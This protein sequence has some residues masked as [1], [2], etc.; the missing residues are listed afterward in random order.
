MGGSGRF[1]ECSTRQIDLRFAEGRGGS[2]QS[3]V[4][5][6]R[7]C[8]LLSAKVTFCRELIFEH[9]AKE[10]STRHGDFSLPTAVMV[11]GKDFAECPTKGSRQRGLCR[12]NFYRG[13]FA[14]SS[15]L[16]RAFV[17]LPS[18]RGARQSSCFR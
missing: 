5:L 13:L 17:L 18:A 4:V 15:S 1:A 8:E 11:L 9:L 3:L 2:R 6:L 14:E 10:P 12:Q 16:P 7:A